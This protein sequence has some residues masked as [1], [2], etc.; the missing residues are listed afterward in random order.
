M[1][2][3]QSILSNSH[4]APSGASVLKL[5][6][7]RE[8]RPRSPY[9]R[10]TIA[11]IFFNS[12][13]RVLVA[14]PPAPTRTSSAATLSSIVSADRQGSGR[15][16]IVKIAA[17]RARLPSNSKKKAPCAARRRICS[18]HCSSGRSSSTVPRF[19][20]RVRDARQFPSIWAFSAFGRLPGSTAH[21]RKKQSVTFPFSVSHSRL[22]PP[23]A[24]RP[25]ER[26]FIGTTWY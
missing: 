15:K 24:G 16:P 19:E 20:Q 12:D 25:I 10:L 22:G 11:G 23:R 3:Y 2:Y 1:Q 6:A 13:E 4:P 9:P 7:R 17:L 8:N 26:F 21:L 14:H 5:A 18:G